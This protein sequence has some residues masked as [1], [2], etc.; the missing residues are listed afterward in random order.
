MHLKSP[1]SSPVA[2]ILGKIIHSGLYGLELHG[3]PECIFFKF[4]SFPY[5][6]NID[7]QMCMVGVPEKKGMQNIHLR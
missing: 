3:F 5:S 6:L 2:L 1:S 4:I 7:P